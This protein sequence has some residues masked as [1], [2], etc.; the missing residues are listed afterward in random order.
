MQSE[1]KRCQDIAIEAFKEKMMGG[2]ELSAQFLD[3]LEG[4]IAVRFQFLIH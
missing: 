1:H 3:K 2:T 4:D